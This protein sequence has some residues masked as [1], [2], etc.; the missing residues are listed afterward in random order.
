L[1]DTQ[2]AAYQEIET[3]KAR[4]VVDAETAAM[5]KFA[6]VGIAEYWEKLAQET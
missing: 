6:D 3:Q 2:I 4:T 5:Q 1:V